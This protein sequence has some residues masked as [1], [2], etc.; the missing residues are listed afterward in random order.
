[1][2]VRWEIGGGGDLCI[3]FVLVCERRREGSIWCSFLVLEG[4]SKR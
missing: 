3:M 2:V 1:M 4:E